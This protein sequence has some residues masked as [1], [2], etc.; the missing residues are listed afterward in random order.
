MFMGLPDQFPDPLVGGIEDPDP[1]QNVWIR[2]TATNT[3]MPRKTQSNKEIPY[4]KH[5][6]SYSQLARGGGGTGTP[7]IQEDPEK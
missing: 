7:L 3:L 2:N 1:Y 6:R 5:K 4:A